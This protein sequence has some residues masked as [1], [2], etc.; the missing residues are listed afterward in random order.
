[1]AKKEKLPA[2]C[3][4]WR[5]QARRRAE[6]GLD[7]KTPRLTSYGGWGMGIDF[8]DHP[9][10]ADGLKGIKRVP[11]GPHRGRVMWTSRKEARE[12]ARYKSDVKRRQVEYDP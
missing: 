3:E 6:L 11:S 10:W 4:G 2:I 9:S 5:E 12:I 7:D 1:M 8:Q